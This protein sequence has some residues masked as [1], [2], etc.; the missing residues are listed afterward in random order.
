VLAFFGFI[1]IYYEYSDFTERTSLGSAF[2]KTDNIMSL[3]FNIPIAFIFSVLYFEIKKSLG[4]KLTYK[5]MRRIEHPEIQEDV[6]I[7]PKDLLSIP[8]A[9]SPRHSPMHS[10]K[11]KMFDFQSIENPQKMTYIERLV[12]LE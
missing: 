11:P 5:L 12:S 7:H 10:E 2:F 9:L 4:D 3:L 8:L 6:V 1:N